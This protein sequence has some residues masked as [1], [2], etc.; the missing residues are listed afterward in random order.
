MQTISFDHA[1]T[2]LMGQL[3]VPEAAAAGA[4]PLV[5]V[6]P[7]ALGLGD[8]ALSAA[9]RLADAGYLGLGVDMYGG[10]LYSGYDNSG[11]DAGR[12]FEGFLKDPQSLRDRALAWF[13]RARTQP[14][15]DPER[16]AAIGY[17]FGGHCVLE[18]ARTGAA[19]KAVVSYHGI[20]TT[21]L[22]APPGTI[23]ARVAAY[24]GARD[25]YAPVATIEALRDELNTAGARHQ[26]T[27][28]NDVEHSFTDPDAG[29]M[30][31]P[32]IAYDAV[33]DRV[34]WA[35]ALALFETLFS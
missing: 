20:L 14:G 33:A 6:F 12:H 21:Q 10:G 27:V 3:A 15:A 11:G 8:H 19:L 2:R 23:L 13:D 35:G 16:I 24:C 28:F 29:K 4:R 18:L 9:R 25:P 17:C 26:I 30:G 31:R 7:S 1:G 22:P 34:S 32:G 5:L